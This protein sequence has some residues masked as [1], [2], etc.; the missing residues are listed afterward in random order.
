M[1][2][3]CDQ[4]ALSKSLDKHLWVSLTLKVHDRRRSLPT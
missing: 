2:P 1:L 3:I 4:S